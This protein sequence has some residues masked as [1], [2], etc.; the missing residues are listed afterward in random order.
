MNTLGMK[1]SNITTNTQIESLLASMTS[2]SKIAMGYPT[3]RGYDYSPLYPF[4]TMP[5]NNCGDPFTETTY[6]VQTHNIER[7]VVSFVAD[8]FRAPKDNHWGYVTNGGTEGNLYG[9]YLA[10]ETLPT[11]KA[12]FSKAAHYSIKK[13]LNI[14]RIECIEIDTD[15][16]DAMDLTDLECKL[17]PETPA[18]ILAT[19]G[20]T[21]KQG[22]DDVKAIKEILT[23]RKMD[24]YIHCDAALDGM[25]A[26]FLTERP[27]FDFVDGADSIAVSGHK[28]IG[29]PIPCGVVVC[30]RDLVDEI[31]NYIPYIHARDET[32]TGS[33]NGITP[34][35]LWYALKQT[36]KE[37]LKEKVAIC[38]E[39]ARYAQKKMIEA[40]IEAKTNKNTIT[41]TFP[42]PSAKMIAKW[43]LATQGDYAHI[44][45]VP[46]VTYEVID[47]FVEDISRSFH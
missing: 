34:L 25:I 38:V 17:D 21:M 15:D 47:S 31:S 20:T 7:E 42:T 22:R 33:R 43:Q 39:K 30:K 3:A 18:I 29:C 16:S 1:S 44:L 37:G 41:V 36:S 24:N 11:A 45:T 32:I 28:F 6:K 10:R 26:P 40:G 2:N 46:G 19:C 8:I 5:I 23:K 35:F 9:L 4:L 27:H 12:Y 13:N 14:L